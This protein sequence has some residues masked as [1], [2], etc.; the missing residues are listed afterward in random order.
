MASVYV[1]K[2]P[3]PAAGDST[4]WFWKKKFKKIL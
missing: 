2:M 4:S 3:L 1:K